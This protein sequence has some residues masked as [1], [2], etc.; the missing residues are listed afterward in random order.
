MPNSPADPLVSPLQLGP[1]TLPNRVLMAPLTRSRSK[2]PGDIPWELN[3]RY[4]AQRASSGLIIAEASQISPQGKGYAFTP[5]IHTDDQAE[6]WRLVTD[7][8]HAAGGRI[9]LQLW[10]VGRISHSDLQPNKQPPVAPSAI[11]AESMTYTSK[12]S[13]RVPVSEPRALEAGE[14]PGIVED[15]RLAARRAIDAGFDGVEI[16]GANGYLLD[17]FLRLA[18]NKRTDEYGG[19]LENRMRFARMVAEAIAAEIGPERTGY[20]ITPCGGLDDPNNPADHPAETFGALAETLSSIGLVY[21]HAVERFRTSPDENRLEST[22]GAIRERFKGVYIANGAYTGDT[23]RHRISSGLADAVAFGRLF[24]SNPDLP[25]RLYKG[26]EL[27]EP[28][29]STFYIGDERGYTDYPAM[30]L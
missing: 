1:L 5:G 22:L 17:Q 4:Y 3:A 30:D 18:C 10:H 21:M 27:V 12:D 6:G 8:V 2:Q 9:F 24:I 13:G 23:A 26:A 19:S 14:I 15:Y 11:R 29:Q 16:H 20:R 25:M 28:D 7:A